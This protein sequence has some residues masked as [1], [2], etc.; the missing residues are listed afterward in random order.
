MIGGP[1]GLRS[2]TNIKAIMVDRFPQLIQT[3]IPK[4]LD[5]PL[6]SLVHSWYVSGGHLYHIL[7]SPAANREFTSGLVGFLYTDG[8]RDRLRWLVQ[9]AKA[10]G[11]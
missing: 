6:R 7:I 11:K 4:V 1:E 8:Y 10:A 5:Y 2:L 9:L 3:G